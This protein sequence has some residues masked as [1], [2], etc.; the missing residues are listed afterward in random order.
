M[1]FTL[2]IIVT[3]SCYLYDNYLYLFLAKIREQKANNNY[4]KKR[5]DLDNNYKLIAIITA[6]TKLYSK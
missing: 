1:Y 6:L 3:L 4:C 5:I 2:S